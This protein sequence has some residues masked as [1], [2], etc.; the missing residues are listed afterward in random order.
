MRHRRTADCAECKSRRSREYGMAVVLLRGRLGVLLLLLLRRPVA[1]G[2]RRGSRGAGMFCRAVMVRSCGGGSHPSAQGGAARCGRAEVGVA[3]SDVGG[4]AGPRRGPAGVGGRAGVLVGVGGTGRTALRG[5]FAGR[6]FCARGGGGEVKVRLRVHVLDDALHGALLLW[7]RRR[8]RWRRRLRRCH[9]RLR[10]RRRLGVTLMLLLRA[11]RPRRSRRP[12]RLPLGAAGAL[13][14][15]EPVVRVAVELG[16]PARRQRRHALRPDHVDL[17][18]PANP[19]PSTRR[20]PAG[21][22]VV[23]RRRPVA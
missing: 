6:C 14:D 23:G 21:L 2:G 18:G 17:V 11:R 4:S 19:S 22:A 9:C 7:R 20:W 16:D 3:A 8:W 10:R 13:V 5:S 15:V 12:R 1:G